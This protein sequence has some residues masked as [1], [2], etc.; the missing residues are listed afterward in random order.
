[1]AKGCVDGLGAEEVGQAAGN[2]VATDLASNIGFSTTSGIHLSYASGT[3][4]FAKTDMKLAGKTV[5]SA[6]TGSPTTW[7]LLVQTG[8][9]V[10]GAGSNAWV[11][12][13]TAFSSTPYVVCNEAQTQG[14][15]AFAPAGSWT[16]GSF[17][18]ETKSASKKVVWT[19]I[20]PA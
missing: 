20:G 15:W 13:G 7:G 2:I 6:G 12:F 4:I 17:Y 10:T 11:T 9:A 5:S 18:V 1:M 16:A 3:N 14:E 8:S 19:A